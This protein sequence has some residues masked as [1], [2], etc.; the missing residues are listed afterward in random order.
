MI[1]AIQNVKEPKLDEAQGRLMPTRI[2]PHQ[3]GI[4]NELESANFSIRRQKA[5]RGDHL[6]AEPRKTRMNRE[7]RPLG[8][9]WIFEEHIEHDLS[10]ID[11]HIVRQARA[12]NV[13]ESLG[14]RS[15]GLV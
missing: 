9:N 1:R 15:E 2:Q 14:V 8:M 10:P 7:T 5:D 4:A 13:S 6:Q 3:A 11:R 12:L